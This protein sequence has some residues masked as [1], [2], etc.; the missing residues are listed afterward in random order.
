M[1]Y[2]INCFH[3]KPVTDPIYHWERGYVTIDIVFSNIFVKYGYEIKDLLWPENPNSKSKH[4]RYVPVTMNNLQGVEQV[5]SPRLTVKQ[6]LN[7][8]QDEKNPKQTKSK[9]RLEYRTNKSKMYLCHDFVKDIYQFLLKDEFDASAFDFRKNP[10][11]KLNHQ[12]KRI[13]TRRKYYYRNE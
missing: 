2:Y 10:L 13:A 7:F 5:P 9:Y 3:K 4:T 6:L 1:L 12:P 8:I 11:N